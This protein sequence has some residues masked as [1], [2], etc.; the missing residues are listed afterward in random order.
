MIDYFGTANA[1]EKN[2]ELEY[3]RNKER[4]EFLRW[5]AGAIDAAFSWRDVKKDGATAVADTKAWQAAQFALDDGRL[6]PG[7]H[8]LSTIRGADR[9]LVFE[10]GR[11]V[12]ERGFGSANLELGVANGLGSLKGA[13]EKKLADGHD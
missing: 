3:E 8:K 1:F 11:I 9:I 13:V 7:W 2:V 10:N 12:H 5:G 4:Y 6:G